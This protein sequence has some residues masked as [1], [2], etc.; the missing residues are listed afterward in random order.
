[1]STD[2]TAPDI[3]H[4][5]DVRCHPAPGDPAPSVPASSDPAP[6]DPAPPG[7]TLR[8]NRDFRRLWIGQAT[9]EFGSSIAALALPLL[10]LA[11]TGS[12]A[13]TG[14]TATLVFATVWA[15]QLPAGYAADRWNRRRVMLICET[16]R[17]LAQL[18]LVA[19]ILTHTVH[20]WLVMVLVVVSSAAWAFFIPA[21]LRTMRAIIRT[22]QIVEAVAVNQARGYTADLL[23]P[24]LGGALFGIG[25]AVPFLVDIVSFAVSGWSVARVAPRADPGRRPAPA[26]GTALAEIRRGWQYVWRQ[27]LLRSSMFYSTAS[28]F[29]ATGLLFSVIIV[30]GDRPGGGTAIGAAVMIASAGGIAGAALAPRAQRRFLVRT[31]LLTTGTLRILVIAAFAVTKQPVLLGMLLAVYILLAPTANTAL[32]ATRTRL[33]PPDILGRA[34]S[35]S[36]FV[37]TGLQPLAPLVFG[38]VLPHFPQLAILSLSALTALVTLYVWRSAGFKGEEAR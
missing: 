20:I 35:S 17:G 2:T 10:I 11:V 24:L 22:D 13:V 27:P 37:A 1:M 8:T 5:P 4:A 18:I 31:I 6:G 34:S 9:S 16:V 29:I 12:A 32:S 26:P 33:I 25:R 19:A 28:N 23:G 30:A 3:E 15:L 21:Q 7:G 36:S 14:L 38:L